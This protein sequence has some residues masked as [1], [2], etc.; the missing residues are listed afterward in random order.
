MAIGTINFCYI[1][2][3]P[4]SKVVIR[5]SRDHNTQHELSDRSKERKLLS[6]ITERGV[7]V[8]LLAVFD[9]GIYNSGF[10]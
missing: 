6:V 1:V 7:G 5:I 9:N 8:K 10:D 3:T 4:N 2:T